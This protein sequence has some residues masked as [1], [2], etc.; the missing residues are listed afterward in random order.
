MIAA[1]M[2]FCLS[3]ALTF[4]TLL[5]L[6]VSQGADRSQRMAT[7]T[8]RQIAQASHKWCP[9]RNFAARTGQKADRSSPET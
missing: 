7:D 3:F 9:P 8:Q 2:V 6:D 4:S 1:I 5:A